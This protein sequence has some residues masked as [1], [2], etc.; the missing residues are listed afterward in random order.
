MLL[1]ELREDTLLRYFDLEKPTFIFTDAHKTGLGATLAQGDSIANAQPV[2]FASRTTNHAE[3]RYPQLDLEAMSIDFGMR[4]FRNYILGSPTPVTVVTDHKPLLPVFNGSRP[5]SIRTERIKMR[6]QDVRYQVVYQKG[7]QNRTDYISR[8]AKPLTKLPLNEQTEATDLNNLLYT[9]HTTPIIDRITLAKI[10]S[11]TAKDETL[12]NLRTIV[13]KGQTFI[14]KS[15]NE[16]LSRFQP[17]L[18]QITVTGNGILLKDERMILPKSLH[19]EAI[20]LAHQGSHTGQSG[21]QRRLR[22]HF[23]FHDM[24]KFVE[25]FVTTCPDCQIFTDKKTSEPI[26]PHTVPSKCWSDVSVDLFGPMPSSKHV[27]V[28]QDM[29]SRF[30]AAKIVTS[31]KAD[32]V[33]PAIADIYDAYGN[34]DTQLADNG[35]PFNSNAMKDFATKRG[36]ELRNTPPLHPA[37]N[38]VETFMKPLGK[39]MKIATHNKSSAKTAL[40]QLLNNYRSTP[41]PATSIPPASM[42]FRDPPNTAFPRVGVD[43]KSIERAQNTDKLKKVQ[44]QQHINSSKYKSK[45]TINEGEWVL[46]RN[47]N[48]SSKFD[49]IFQQEPCKVISVENPWVKLERNGTIYRR[50]LDDIKPCVHMQKQLHVAPKQNKAITEADVIQMWQ[51]KLQLCLPDEENYVAQKFTSNRQPQ[52]IPYNPQPNQQR[53]QHHEVHQKEQRGQKKL[54]RSE[55]QQHKQQQRQE[56]QQ[57]QRQKQLQQRRPEIE[58][59]ANGATNNCTTVSDN[60]QM[61]QRNLE[62]QPT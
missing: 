39:A 53:Y 13:E 35:P 44:R 26:Q 56:H 59:A 18:P 14:P 58:T 60:V 32:K 36:I 54:R 41:H 42:L 12:S 22:Y 2:A 11:E 38:P 33:I 37:S 5:G 28:V 19:L 62:N 21:I 45:T 23:F 50:H 48:K 61:Q 49:P 27:V 55:R 16:S 17:I 34:P 7:S 9:L 51:R 43:T 24:N 4:R 1:K 31:T 15:A 46:I 47:F 20:K 8:H 57:Q 40:T 10:S 25:Q 52:P 3:T 30:P 29:A 6:H